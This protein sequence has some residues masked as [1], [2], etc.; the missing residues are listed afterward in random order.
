VEL[1]GYTVFFWRAGSEFSAARC[2]DGHGSTDATGHGA[3]RACATQTLTIALPVGGTDRPHLRGV[4]A[5]APNLWWPDAPHR[6]RHAQ[7]PTSAKYSTTSVLSPNPHTSPR[8]TGLRCGMNVM[9]RR[10]RGS[11]LSQTGMAWRNRHPTMRLISASIGEGM[12]RRMAHRLAV[13]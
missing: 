12:Q 10:V 13:G 3:A 6:V 4:S 9:C 11:K 8:H 7:M 5:T 1:K 2:S